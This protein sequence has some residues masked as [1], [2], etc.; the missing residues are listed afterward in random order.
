M[1]TV[2]AAALDALFLGLPPVGLAVAI[3]RNEHRI[4]R[5]HRK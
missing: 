1:S 5:H 4:H 2:V 3:L